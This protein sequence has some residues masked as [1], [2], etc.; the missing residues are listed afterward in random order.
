MRRA[1]S[2]GP[3]NGFQCHKYLLEGGDGV[4]IHRAGHRSLVEVRR[5]GIRRRSRRF[6]SPV[7]APPAKG[8]KAQIQ[9]KGAPSASS[10]RTRAREL[11][12]FTPSG[13][14]MSCGPLCPAGPRPRDQVRLDLPSTHC[15]R[16]TKSSLT[17]SVRVDRLLRVHTVVDRVD[18]R[19][20]HCG[21]DAAA[22]RRAD[23][24]HRHAVLVQ[25]GR[26]H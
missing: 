26:A 4:R 11:T 15:C 18:D 23:H 6:E 19:V 8:R 25:D 12:G 22:A 21:D 1:L 24:H 10:Q 16:S 3:R 9:C 2:I 14:R 17:I 5:D 7:A 20:H 13:R